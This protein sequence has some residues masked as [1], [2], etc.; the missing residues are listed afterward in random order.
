[1][2]DLEDFKAVSNHVGSFLEVTISN[3]YGATPDC[4]G[5]S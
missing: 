2:K 1:M 4:C 5:T 3:S